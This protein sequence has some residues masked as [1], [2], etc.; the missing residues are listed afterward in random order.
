MSS[1]DNCVLFLSPAVYGRAIFRPSSDLK[2][3]GCELTE[4]V[5]GKDGE[6]IF[7]V[8][9]V[10]RLGGFLE[11]QIVQDFDT[12]P[13]C[14]ITLWHGLATVYDPHTESKPYILTIS[15]DGGDS[16]SD[17]A[18]QDVEEFKM[19]VEKLGAFS[20]EILTAYI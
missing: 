8:S 19:V 12:D 2:I 11:R 4:A 17:V 13:L 3:I 18:V 9:D 15:F 6:L 5:R 14:F 20:G 16:V 7:D 10:I 1:A